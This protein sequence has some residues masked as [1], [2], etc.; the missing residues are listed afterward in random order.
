M[1]K[2][3]NGIQTAAIAAGYA[4]GGGTKSEQ[5]NGTAWT[6]TPALPYSTYSAASGGT[7]SAGFVAGGGN[8]IKSD[9]V[10]W[11]GEGYTAGG[12]L[13]TGRRNTCGGGTQTAGIIMGG[14]DG[15]AS[16][17]TEGYDG[18]VWSSRPSMGTA[19]YSLASSTAG[20]NTATMVIAGAAAGGTKQTI[21]EEFTGETSV[22]GPASNITTS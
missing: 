3:L 4:P 5:Y 7:T 20:P 17:A 22:A 21:T 1:H 6:T 13:I 9:T 18:T 16:S 11:D 8:P 15:N 10:E 14:Y 19:R 12:S 2:Y